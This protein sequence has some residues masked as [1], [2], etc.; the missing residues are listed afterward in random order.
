MTE[1]ATEVE[2]ELQVLTGDHEFAST[3]GRVS[4]NIIGKS[5]DTG[6][7]KLRK[8]QF[9]RSCWIVFKVGLKYFTVTMKKVPKFI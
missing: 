8:A 6:F 9:A 7:R 5:G 2:Y 4:V 3:N 1:R